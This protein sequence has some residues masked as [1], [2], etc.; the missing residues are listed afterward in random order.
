VIYETASFKPE[1]KIE[2]VMN[3]ESDEREKKYLKRNIS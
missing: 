3:G 2:G 1:V